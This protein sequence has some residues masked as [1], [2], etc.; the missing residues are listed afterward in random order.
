MHNIFAL[1][2]LFIHLINEISALDKRVYQAA[3]ES[4]KLSSIVWSLSTLSWTDKLLLEP[5]SN[6]NLITYTSQVAIKPHNVWALSIYKGTHSLDNFEAH[7][8][9]AL[10]ALTENH[11]A[12][13]DILGKKSGK[14]I[15]KVYMM[16]QMGFRLDTLANLSHRHDNQDSFKKFES[17]TV[18]DDAPFIL[19]VEHLVEHPR[20]DLGD[21]WL[22]LCKVEHVKLHKDVSLLFNSLLTTNFLRNT[23]VI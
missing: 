20:I 5:H 11:I 9:G 14:Q 21:H 1:L 15:N 22:Y 19:C 13:F 2:S 17:L 16:S 7:G 4:P 3:K 6:M 10:Q 23:G 8:F 18:F 12:C